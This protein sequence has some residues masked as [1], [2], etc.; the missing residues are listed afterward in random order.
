MLDAWFPVWGPLPGRTKS[1]DLM[2]PLV[3]KIP[4]EWHVA[5]RGEKAT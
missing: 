5:V 3:L 2:V 4:D 1:H